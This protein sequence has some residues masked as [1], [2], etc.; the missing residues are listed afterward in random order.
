MFQAAGIHY[1]GSLYV[2]SSWHTLPGDL[3]VSSWHT[4]PGK[5]VCFKQLAYTSWE[6]CMFQ[7][8][9]LHYLRSLYVTCS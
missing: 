6:A 4:L 7:A 9:G 5:L 3:N 1:L 2:S 8:A